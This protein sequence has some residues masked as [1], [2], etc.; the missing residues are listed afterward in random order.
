LWYSSYHHLLC[1]NLTFG[2][3]L[4]LGAWVI[5]P[6]RWLNASLALLSFHLHLGS[7]LLGSRG[8]DGY[9]WPIHYLYPFSN[10]CAMAWNGQWALNAWPNYVVTLLAL[11]AVFALAWHRG[12]SPLSMVSAR[13]D[14]AFVRTI[15]RRWPPRAETTAAPP[16]SRH[17]DKNSD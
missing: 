4:A 14:Q 11:L 5:G 1:H 3:V 16:L 7:D 2:L 9:Q 6:R 17:R 12:Y 15:R 13:A 10:S 8:P